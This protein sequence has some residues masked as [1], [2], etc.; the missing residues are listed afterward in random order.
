MKY[1]TILNYF[2]QLRL[3]S[4]LDF[5]ILATALTKNLNVI[6][7][8]SLLWL[9][10]LLYLESRHNDTPRLKVN[11]YLW[12]IPFVVSLVLLPIWI[13]VGFALFSYLYT[14]KKRNKFFGA[15]APFWRASQNGIIA[16][17]FNPQ[18]AI[19][20]FVLIFIRNLIADF[21][22][23]Y[24]DEQRNIK[25]IPVLLGV[26]KNQVWA[27]YIH[28]FLVIGTTTVWFHYSFLDI[29]LLLPTIILQLISYPLIPR[30]SNPKYLNIYA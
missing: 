28:I 12:L 21:R 19:L 13:Y 10:F 15:S 27:F 16:F 8:I 7:G 29:R 30:L 23:A 6:L 1:K 18:I 26:N 9:S 11:R 25:T 17:G 4:F 5:I 22:D 2:G 14:N 3:Y 24:N 20:V